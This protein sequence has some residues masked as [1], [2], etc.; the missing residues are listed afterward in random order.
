MELSYSEMLNEMS[1]SGLVKRLERNQL[2]TLQAILTENLN[3]QGFAFKEAKSQRIGLR[4]KTMDLK[5]LKTSSSF[6]KNKQRHYI[7][8]LRAN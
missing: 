3:I 6:I 5:S 2:Y 4:C 7:D 1:L 8:K